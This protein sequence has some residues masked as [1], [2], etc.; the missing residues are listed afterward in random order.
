[1]A[2]QLLTSNH[3]GILKLLSDFEPI[4]TNS[5]ICFSALYFILIKVN[6]VQGVIS[7]FQSMGYKLGSFGLCP[8]PTVIQSKSILFISQIADS[9][10]IT[11]SAFRNTD[12][13]CV[14]GHAHTYTAIQTRLI[15]FG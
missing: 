7:W 14:A 9:Q 2:C 1:M 15:R 6:H 13:L 5:N 11:D 12:G 10:A 3:P 4:G 8:D